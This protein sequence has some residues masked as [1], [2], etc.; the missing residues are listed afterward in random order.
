MSCARFPQWWGHSF[1]R[2]FLTTAKI[3]ILPRFRA[4]KWS[5]SVQPS[6]RSLLSA[7][8]VLTYRPL[9]S[10]DSAV[11]W[12]SRENKG[13]DEVKTLMSYRSLLSPSWVQKPGLTAPD[14]I[15][16]TTC[17]LL[18][19]SF[20]SAAEI[21]NELVAEKLEMKSSACVSRKRMRA[22]AVRY[23][24]CVGQSCVKRAFSHSSL[25][26]ARSSSKPGARL[27]QGY[28]SWL[29]WIEN[30]FCALEN[31]GTQPVS[32]AATLGQIMMVKLA[33]YRAWSSC[34]LG[35]KGKRRAG[36]IKNLSHTHILL[37]SRP[38]L[39]MIVDEWVEL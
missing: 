37:F 36:C 39:W 2:C 17:R 21:T 23:T 31:N 18:A 32:I 29:L 19:A 34:L 4:F 38:C 33:V 22:R 16:R 9:T 12:G 25:S 30:T 8:N 27:L 13:S 14:D 15:D 5:S 20:G 10:H 6:A 7:E 35:R 11:R 26:P 3:N 1:V 24:R 28:D